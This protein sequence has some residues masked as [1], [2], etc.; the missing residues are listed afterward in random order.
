MRTIA[1]LLIMASTASAAKLTYY[2][3]SANE[4]RWRIQ[5]ENNRIIADS[6]EGYK[7]RVDCEHAVDL[8]KQFFKEPDQVLR[9]PEPDAKK[10]EERSV[11]PPCRKLWRL[12]C[13]G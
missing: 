3:D 6:G 1:L 12:R 10:A 7:N 5:A 2:K 9:D 11:L 8:L 4:W 13:R